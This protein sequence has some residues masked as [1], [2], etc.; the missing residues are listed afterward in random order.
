[1]HIV[2]DRRNRLRNRAAL[3]SFA[4][5]VGN[6]G[7]GP[8][9]ADTAA[10]STSMPPLQMSGTPIPSPVQV[11][12]V[13]TPDTP[14]KGKAIFENIAR[15]IALANEIHFDARVSP[16][17]LYAAVEI[18]GVVTQN[19]CV[20]ITVTKGQT[21]VAK[22]VSNDDHSGVY[23]PLSN[24][25][26]TSDPITNG[27]M[28]AD[29]SRMIEHQ[30]GANTLTAITLVLSFFCDAIDGMRSM[31]GSF[32]G[33]TFTHAESVTV[34]SIPVEIETLYN[35]VNMPGKTNTLTIVYSYTN[36]PFSIRSVSAHISSSGSKNKNSAISMTFDQCILL[37][38]DD[39]AT[40]SAQFAFAAPSG[41]I[42]ST[43]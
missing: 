29:M 36:T 12:S 17:S 26:L 4:F 37:G 42:A 20:Q 43:K 39:P 19:D 7:I 8:V 38:Q 28:T 34:G 24:K 23:T 18:S 16:D 21:V 22:I 35:T 14:Q 33:G 1:M 27:N 3:A 32:N 9:H 6:C 2:N 31:E 25:Y 15:Q 11:P 10:T 40:N 41:A 13:I 30:T 5:I